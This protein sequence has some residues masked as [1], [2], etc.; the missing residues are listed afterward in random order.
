MTATATVRHWVVLIA[1][2]SS[3]PVSWRN[4]RALMMN[5]APSEKLWSLGPMMKRT[6]P[7]QDEH[8]ADR[9]HDEDDRGTADPAVVAEYQAV[10]GKRGGAGGQD[11]NRQ[12]QQAGR[13]RSEPEPPGLE[14]PGDQDRDH[15]AE[16]HEIAVREVGKPQD[17]EHQRDA[18]RTER[19]LGCVGES[20][21][22]HVVAEQD[23]RVRQVRQHRRGQPPRNARRTSGSASSAAPV[24]V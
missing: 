20:G 11:G 21:D 18:Q 23:D 8:D 9:G 3:S 16:C 7:F 24:S 22:D 12:C 15:G 13:Q 19:E 6:M 1:R 10:G 17:P 2:P 14:L 5:R 4:S